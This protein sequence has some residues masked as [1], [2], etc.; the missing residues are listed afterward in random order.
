MICADRV[1]P[2]QIDQ[3]LVT[4]MRASV[5]LLGALLARCGEANLPMPGGDAIGLRSIDLH[6]AGLR[7]MGAS[8]DVAGGIIRAAA[9]SGLRGTEVILPQPSVG[10][11]EN[12]LLAAVLAT[13]TTVI[14][15]AAREPEIADLAQCL[16]TM[17]ARISGIQSDTLTVEGG[18]DLFGAVY[19]VMPDRIEMGTIACA[20]AITNGEVLLRHGRLDL[21][22][23]AAPALSE[24]GVELRQTADGVIARRSPAGLVGIDLQTRPYP[25]F[26][27]DLQAPVMALLSTAVGASLVTETIFEHRFRHVDEL[28]KLGANIKV[29][30]RAA[31]VRGMPKLRGA[32]VMGMDVRGAGA[33]VVAGLAADGQTVVAGLEHIDRGYDRMAEKLV[34]CGADI[35][36]ATPL[37]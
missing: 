6:V 27:T 8:I 31:L 16:T 22:G 36:R 10:A 21:L 7:A 19:P 20:A 33:L 26:A 17:G 28:R 29:F 30:G 18:R 12:L 5:L 14:R 24:A 9:H 25:G 3:D 13:G 11:T 23:A 32:T 4:R 15:N 35:I 34:A 1:H 2:S 37:Q